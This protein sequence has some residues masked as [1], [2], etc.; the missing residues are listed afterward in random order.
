[1]SASIVL[2]LTD[3]EKLMFPHNYAAAF[4]E[5]GGWLHNYA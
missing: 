3:R 1:M 4:I 2:S 5:A